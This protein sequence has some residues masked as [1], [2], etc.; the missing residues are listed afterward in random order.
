MV[1][2]DAE[3]AL[4][5]SRAW[6]RSRP[7]LLGW[8]ARRRYRF[9]LRCVEPPPSARVID[10]GGS[11]GIFASMLVSRG[12]AEVTVVE[13]KPRRYVDGIRL[14]RDPRLRFVHDDI[15]ARLDLLLG[16]DVVSALH[17]LHQLGA[18]VHRL[19]DAVEASSVRLVVLQGSMSHRERVQPRHEQELWGP[20]LG[21]PHGMTRLLEAHG[22]RSRIHPHR[23]YPVVV[24]VR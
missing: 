7:G 22:F 8:R 17:C 15:C 2:A 21:L 19:F 6:R 12:A 5:S 4:P 3:Q 23:R 9:V 20:A 18:T 16:A 1:S 10:V 14:H 24:G 11:Q 13:A